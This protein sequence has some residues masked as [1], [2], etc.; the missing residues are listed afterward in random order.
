MDHSSLVSICIPTYNNTDR[1]RG[2]LYSL[3]PQVKQYSI[4]IYVSDNASTDNTIEMLS[5]F[6]KEIYPLLYYRSNEKNLGFDQNIV[7]AVNMSS[8]K[9]VWPMG[10]RRRLLPNS[11]RRVY[12]ILSRNDL[13]LLILSVSTH[14]TSVQNKRYKLARNVFLDLWSNAGTLGF[15]VMPLKAWKLEGLKKYVGTFWI[16]FAVI[17]EFLASL[18]DVDVM[19][20]GWPSI[21]SYGKSQWTNSLFQGWANWKNVVRELPNVYSNHDKESIIRAWSTGSFSA[22]VLLYLRSEKVYNSTLY[23]A[24]RQ[25]FFNYT[26]IPLV[27]A[28][29]V[30]QLPILFAKL[31]VILERLLSKA[32]RMFVHFRYPLN[33]F[34]ARAPLMNADKRYTK[35][36]EA[37]QRFLSKVQRDTGSAIYG[38]ET[39]RRALEEGA[40]DTLMLSEEPMPFRVTRKCAA[41]GNEEQQILENTTATKPQRSLVKKH[42]PK[43]KTGFLDVA[44]IQD[45]RENLLELAEQSSA[46]VEIVSTSTEEGQR[47]R[48]SFEGIAALLKSE[49]ARDRINRIT[50]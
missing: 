31:Y 19:F 17:F 16:H 47:L 38:E 13:D 11:M 36:K 8:T 27:E 26:N 6:K 25:D 12:N 33:P 7:N 28:K 15:F 2:C 10:D 39:V 18:K 22:Q 14:V 32:L 46:Q 9:Y 23:N 20:T 44:E 41:C 1:L 35:E 37:M 48:N 24:Y 50:S 40:V 29:I 4:P 34:S 3:V 43:C 42:C 49:D 45:L 30:S 21:A 5:S